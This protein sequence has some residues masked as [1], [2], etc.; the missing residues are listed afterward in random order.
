MRVAALVDLIFLE[1]LYVI[2]VIN[3]ALVI[4]YLHI[5]YAVPQYLAHLSLCPVLALEIAVLLEVL[6][7]HLERRL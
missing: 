5:T 2:N 4:S 1:Y 3:Y 7:L 6:D